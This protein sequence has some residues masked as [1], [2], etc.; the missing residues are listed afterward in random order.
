MRTSL[1]GTVF[2]SS[3]ERGPAGRIQPQPEV[4]RA[5]PGRWPDASGRQ[6][7]SGS[8]QAAYGEKGAEKSAELHPDLDVELLGVL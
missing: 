5:G 8:R 2:D 6:T 7:G 1:D 4:I 3:Y